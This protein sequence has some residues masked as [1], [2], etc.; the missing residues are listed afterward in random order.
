[1]LSYTSNFAAESRDL[2]YSQ[3]E[4]LLL[5]T[6]CA[7]LEKLHQQH[8]ASSVLTSRK[9]QPS[10]GSSRSS[11]SSSR[12]WDTARGCGLAVPVSSHPD[13]A[14]CCTVW[15]LHNVAAVHTCCN[16]SAPIGRT[17]HSVTGEL[18]TLAPY[19]F[20]VR[21]PAT[22]KTDISETENNLLIIES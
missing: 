4:K 2:T 20:T 19:S 5:I 3:A 13:G 8:P 9:Q 12:R 14:F 18:N 6:L 21:L 10:G 15:S 22:V 1:M 17:L 7:Y 11:S 16:A